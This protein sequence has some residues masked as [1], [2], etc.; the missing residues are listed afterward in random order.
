MF[1]RQV[2]TIE[3][4]VNM[5]LRRQGLETPLQQRRLIEAWPKAVGPMIAK[6]T[7]DRFIR[8]QTLFVKVNNPAL[9][10]ELSM[11]RSELVKRLNTAAGAM[12]ITDIRYY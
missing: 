12:L 8:N 5:T 11:R 6:Y 9:R 10:Y 4:L 7:G 1:R 2:K 3:E